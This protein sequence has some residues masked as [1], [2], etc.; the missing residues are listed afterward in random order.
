MI[1]DKDRTGW[2]GASDTKYITGNWKTKTFRLWWL[3][4]MG[5][6][7]NEFEN[8]YMQA[9]SEYEHRILDSL[10]LPII[11]DE[12]IMIEDLLLR[13]NLDGRVDVT[14]YEVKTYQWLKGFKVSK[15]Y[16]EQVQ[17]QMFGAKLKRA[18]IVAYGLQEEDYKNYFR[19]I[20]R[21]RLSLIPIEYD[22][23]YITEEYLPKLKILVYCLKNGILPEVAIR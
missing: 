12:Q 19:D 22:P 6:R 8:V 18:F 14:D 9:G 21:E 16:Y 13:I 17:V 7:R 10:G 4:K 23:A 20:D 5:L 15:A 1:T 2:F 11:K 3:E